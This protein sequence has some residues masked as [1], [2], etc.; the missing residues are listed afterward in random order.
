[1]KEN[2]LN[3]RGK[4]I[5]PNIKKEFD[6]FL[7]N[8][9]YQAEFDRRIQK[10]LKTAKEKWMEI[11]DLEKS[12]EERLLK[13]N[14]EERLEYQIK[15][16]NKE[17]ANVQSKLNAYELKDKALKIANER[18]LELSLLSLI[19]FNTITEDNLEEN[20]N[21][22]FNIFNRAVEKSIKSKLKEIFWEVC[23]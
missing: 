10:A 2:I 12:E 20:I 14:K 19:D 9:M 1:M 13:M 23:K 17:K 4:E 3:D 16:V 15:K 7:K 18:N 22:M 21:N 6:K 11:N 8:K 5:R